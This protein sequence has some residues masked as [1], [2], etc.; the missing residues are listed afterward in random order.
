MKYQI[1]VEVEADAICERLFEV[2][3]NEYFVE[4]LVDDGRK[5]R[6]LLLSTVVD[7][8]SSYLPTVGRDSSTDMLT[9]TIRD[10]ELAHRLIDMA[11]HIEAIGSFWLG[12]SKVYWERPIR[13]WIGD[14][15]EELDLLK[16]LPNEWKETRN[17]KDLNLK[18][19][20][21]I[22]GSIIANRSLH[23]NL[24]LPMSFYREG[25]NDFKRGYY[26]NAFVNF[27]FY[28][29]DIYGAGATKNKQVE[30]RLK[31]SVHVRAAV[32]EAIEELERPGPS[33]NLDQVMSFLLEERKPLTVDGVIELIVQIRGNL[34]H[35]SQKSTKRKGHAFNQFDFRGVAYL[36]QA[37]C[38]FTFTR[39]TTGEPPR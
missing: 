30:E 27:Y 19:T 34:A 9:F 2:R 16:T 22:L 24:T 38:I 36:L 11:Q 37:V 29:D 17:E 7:N 13:R 23:A 1:E 32:Q 18:V 6:A 12:I 35:F 14:T 28:L 31:K 25:S 8:Y 4:P 10:G 15:S 20:P 3:I 39:L 5:L 33:E 21:E 26:A